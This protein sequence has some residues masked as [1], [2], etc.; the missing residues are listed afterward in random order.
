MK[1]L[2]SLKSDKFGLF[3]QDKLNN[4]LAI[5]GGQIL[6]TTWKTINMETGEQI[7]SGT[8]KFY[9]GSH[10]VDAQTTI[11]PH[12]GTEGDLVSTAVGG[13]DPTLYE[14]IYNLD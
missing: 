7:D 4:P 8:D 9:T 2:E 6:G 11:T 12:F 10:A 13:Y 1:K 3:E 5:T 14:Q